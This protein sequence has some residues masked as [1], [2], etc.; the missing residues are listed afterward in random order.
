MMGQLNQEKVKL[1]L[2]SLG[3]LIIGL[4]I[5]DLLEQWR[6]NIVSILEE[7]VWQDDK[8]LLIQAAAQVVA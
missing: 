3:L 8:G 5:P 6:R 4:V 1:I 2:F 7:C